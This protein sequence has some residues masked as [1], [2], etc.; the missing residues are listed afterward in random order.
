MQL[1]GAGLPV[2]RFRPRAFDDL[3]GYSPAIFRSDLFAGVTVGIVALPLAM[4]FAIASG[5]KP[6]AGLVTAVIA[7]FLISFLGGSRV[8]IGG[9]AGAFIVVV[10]GIVQQHGLLNLAISTIMAGALLFLMGLTRIGSLVRFVPVA[11]VTGFTNGIA[12][13]I[14][15]SQLRDLLGL[16]IASLPADFVG[17]VATLWAK[18]STFNPVAFGLAMGCLGLLLVWPRLRLPIPGA[19]VVLTAATALTAVTDLPVE[20][21]GSRFGGIPTGLPAFAPPEWSWGNARTLVGPALT[22]ALLGAVESLLCARVADA[23]IHGRHDPNQELMAQGIANMVAPM[24][25]GMAATGT[26]ARTMTSIR[27]GARTPAAGM[28]HALTVLAVMLVAAPL[29]FHVPLGALAAILMH[30]ALNMGEWKAFAHLKRYSPHYRTILLATFVLTVVVDLTVAVEIG[31]VLAGLFFILRVSAL[32]TIEPIALAPD[33]SAI[34]PGVAAYKVQ[35]SL[36]FASVGK[37][38]ELGEAVADRSPAALVLD[39]HYVMNM[40]TTAMEAMQT[41]RRGLSRRGT[42]LVL[43][44]A[45]AQPH[46]LMSRS[47]FRAEIGADNLKPDLQAALRRAAAIAASRP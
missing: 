29:A 19:I 3:R 37:L 12:V 16:R 11:I 22:I 26:I 43:C 25:G 10:Y 6:E 40:D 47:G 9:P 5:L 31:L 14:A 13:L 46:S 1:P 28:L 45:Q 44:G 23:L 15:L 42:T 30:V 8:Q 27:A 4:A 34:P 21:I 18:A 24:F 20:T 32:T 35:G 2:H 33:G 38:D 39:L 7:G 41:L 17:Q 36:F